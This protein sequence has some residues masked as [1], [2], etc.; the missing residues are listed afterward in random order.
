[1]D[2]DGTPLVLKT[3]LKVGTV[4]AL[5][6]GCYFGYVR[7]FDMVVRQ[8]RA[9]RPDEDLIFP[10]LSSKSKQRA[11]EL[12][13]RTVG[14][15]HWAVTSDL[16]FSYY[17]AERGFW[18]FAQEYKSI[19]EENGVRYDGKRLKLWP[20]L[21]I[22]TSSDGKS[23]QVL[24]S[25]RATLD[26]NQPIGL[27]NKQT[28]EGIK[29]KHAY[30]EG[31]VRIRDDK[32]TPTVLADDM[33]IG[34]L[35]Y[36]EFDDDTQQI[37][38]E[39]HVVIQDPDQTITGDGLVI[40]LR[41]PEAGEAQAKSSSAGFRGVEYAI[42]LKNVRVAMRDVGSSGMLPSSG[43]QAARKTATP[44]KTAGVAANPT[45]QEPGAKETKSPSKDEPVPL[46]VKSEGPMRIDVPPDRE[47]VAVGPPE[48]PAPTLVRFERN[49]VAWRGLVDPDQL[50]CD[51]LR[52]TLVPG[53]QPEARS[54]KDASSRKADGQDKPVGPAH[55]A[56]SEAPAVAAN[57][58]PS[59]GIGSSGESK[60]GQPPGS[61]DGS[62]QEQ[63]TS[64]PPNKGLF[65]NLTLQKAH[66]TGHAVWLQ[67]RVQGTKVRCNEMIHERCM[68]YRPDYTLFRGDRTRQVWMEKLDYEPE[69]PTKGS[70]EDGER[71][72]SSEPP[73]K[74]A[75]EVRSVTHVLTV[76]ATIFERGNGMDLADVRAEG[77]GRLETRPD[78]DQPVER[79][80][81]WQDELIIFNLVGSEGTLQQ[82]QVTLT[83]TR[84]LFVDLTRN[85]RLDSGRELKVFLKPRTP[86]AKPASTAGAQVV[87]DPHLASHVPVRTPGTGP[88]TNASPADGRGA[89]GAD[90]GATSGLGGS[91]QI[92]RLLAYQDVHLIAPNRHME[93][94]EWLD[95]P[96][97][98]VDPAPAK[99]ESAAVKTEEAAGDGTGAEGQPSP[100]P[101]EGAPK[102]EDPA[103]TPT[104]GAIAAKDAQPETP[105]EPA[106]TG[107][108]DRIWAKIALPRGKGID[109]GKPRR[110]KD[111][112]TQKGA[113][114]GS[115][116]AAADAPASGSSATATESPGSKEAEAE[117][118][119]AWLRGNVALHQDKPPDPN[120]K[121]Q[122]KPQGSD[123]CGEAVYLE[124]KG[125]G[126]ASVRVYHRDPTNPTPLLGPI[127][128]AKVST[129]EMLVF[130][131]VL[132]LDQEKDKIWGFGPG[133]W[134][135]WTDRAVMSDKSP[136]S[137]PAAD[138]SAAPPSAVVA[139]APAASGTSPAS[140]TKPRTRAGKPIGDK[141]LLT[142]TWTKQM[143]FTGRTKDPS[144]NPAGRADFLGIV[145]AKMTDAALHCEQKMIVFTDREVPLKQLASATGG[146]T[147]QRAGGDG[148]DLPDGDENAEREGADRSRVDIAMIYCFG[149]P[150][151][152]SRK[153]DPDFPLVL[154]QERID[155]WIKNKPAQVERLDY[156]RRTGEFFVPGPGMVFLYDRPE[157]KDSRG[158][159]DEDQGA[160]AGNGGAARGGPRSANGRTITPTSTR[161][162]NRGDGGPATT[163]RDATVRR[164]PAAPGTPAVRRTSQ[165]LVLMQVKFSNGMKG[166]VGSGR[167][168]DTDE[169]RWSEF[170]G[171]IEFLRS[172]VKDSALRIL[173]GGPQE[174]LSPDQRLSD[175][176]FYLTSQMLRIIQE[177]PPVGSPDKTPARNW[178]K[179]WDKVH[180]NKGESIS[181]ESDVATY[182]S[183]TDLVWA[184]GEDEHGVTMVQQLG[185]G[186]QA[187]VNHGK[188]VQYNLKT[189]T[190]RNI[191]ADVIN[192]IDKRTGAR[193]SNQG[194][195][196]PTAQP[197]KKGKMPYKV[198]NT[199]LERRGF[200]G[201]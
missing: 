111:K 26:M 144:G 167:A 90:A 23:A 92:E 73:T 114:D 136:D 106:M 132:W 63:E 148:A 113:G 96:F 33:R 155:A 5:L 139:G 77:P 143:E 51:V 110:R 174:V 64:D 84:P 116:L 159:N 31:D 81:I 180:I 196:D 76:S 1:M 68:P 164:Q 184:Y 34:P 158:D 55:S 163:V 12:A 119:E 19:Q 3:L 104:T 154:E 82:K 10:S 20:C 60:S 128:W 22:W 21:M 130:G 183:A 126:K 150:T 74:K 162:P 194:I 115:A 78:R 140:A 86:E 141:D 102:A 70:E 71:L 179:A 14:A 105:A 165:P 157:E 97:I 177:P 138:G 186:Q 129:D 197:K 123:I 172:K 25:D 61:G 145:D 149:K 88:D 29:V 13:R 168:K 30:I 49:V 62:V 146:K 67:M 135:Q 120:K 131:E 79:I 95:A 175:D 151:A 69:E 198:P 199:N 99:E 189:R 109:A 9:E 156:N 178:A 6:L 173:P 24:E 100:A 58:G 54:P 28:G 47:P 101:T 66:A 117:V 192:L 112:K 75:R 127:R 108:A 125:E 53:P 153:V 89:A 42:L 32:G 72:A 38:S 190:G 98:E 195:P 4:S 147:R 37:T 15:N 191:G 142:I 2:R 7:A 103:K 36:L 166:R 171:N 39:S 93:A 16:P 52:L 133:T 193:P 48:P 181:I 35:T 44:A 85:T 187:S 169:E 65:G 124:N 40:Q 41:K 200:T 176:G 83:G 185:P 91:M 170:Y 188:A 11:K 17:N 121:D 107:V 161:S 57:T 152:I 43:P 45:A 201:Q 160:A 59:A 56:Q 50:D 46:F 137:Q 8:F 118:R 182:D 80:A 134:N 122:A 94:R 87:T 18:M 27:A